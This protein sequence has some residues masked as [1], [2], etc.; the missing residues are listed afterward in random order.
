M[1]GIIICF[2]ICIIITFRYIKNPN[3]DGFK[4]DLLVFAIFTILNIIAVFTF[5]QTSS[6]EPYKII[7]MNVKNEE[8]EDILYLDNNGVS[9]EW[10]QSFFYS[11]SE[12]I[13]DA[14]LEEDFVIVHDQIY[15]G[16]VKWVFVV[17]KNPGVTVYT[18]NV[19]TYTDA[20]WGN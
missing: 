18:G 16:W 1:I 14:S 20:V 12:I 15:P 19:N 11:N 8:V 10:N 17:P 2:V 6:S 4:Y 9:N 3:E 5:R 7:A 13:F